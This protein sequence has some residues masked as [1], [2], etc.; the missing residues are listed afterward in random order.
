MLTEDTDDCL[1]IIA[2]VLQTDMTIFQIL[3]QEG[4]V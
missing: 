4:A 1:A 2:F 3:L